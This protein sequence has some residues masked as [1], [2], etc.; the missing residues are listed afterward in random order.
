MNPEDYVALAYC[1]VTIATLTS[2]VNTN[3]QAAKQT[4]RYVN[5]IL[6]AIG[7]ATVT[8][9]IISMGINANSMLY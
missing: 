8:Y 3:N 1:V 7:T 4:L 6:V 9:V 2:Y 5:S